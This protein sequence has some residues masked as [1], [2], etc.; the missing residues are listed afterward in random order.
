[1]ISRERSDKPLLKAENIWVVYPDGTIAN[2]G[3]SI[4]VYPGEVHGLLGENGAG[5]TSLVHAIYGVV[6][7]SLGRILVDGREVRI[8][9]PR[10][11][12]RLGIFMVPQHNVLIPRFSGRENI[13]L[14]GD[15]K[16]LARAM[17]IISSI[18]IDLDIESPV[19]TL[20]R[21]LVKK[22]EVIRALATGARLLILD[23]PTSVMSPIEARELLEMIRGLRE[24]GYSFIYI[25]HRLDEVMEV[26]DRVT[27]L[28]GGSVSY[29]GEPS[30]VRVLEERMFREVDVDEGVGEVM[31][32]LN[33]ILGVEGN[34]QLE[35]ARD[36]L[37]YNGF[38]GYVPSYPYA[39]IVPGMS[40]V[41]NVRFRVLDREDV[42]PVET[43]KYILE[44][45]EVLARDIYMDIGKLSGGNIQRFVVGRELEIGRDR[46]VLMFPSR[47][48]DTRSTRLIWMRVREAAERGVDVYYFT[49]DVMEAVN[50]GG[51][52]R[53]M[54]R[55][56]VSDGVDSNEL[57]VEW[58]RRLMSGIGWNA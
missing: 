29:V 55:R 52:V 40:L 39:S 47:G 43:A 45:Y 12:R 41:D 37:T 22:I 38:V 16:T 54:Y 27:I 32:N 56:R 46:C 50:L 42:N 14:A 34:G 18:D 35:Y 5:K 1:V 25:S 23:E 48:L 4:S 3:V 26:C 2:K 7:P 28:R 10:H 51:V 24:M 15:R 58:A 21:G 49:E 9:S 57:D 11:A 13:L 36:L 53:I 30:D 6:R 33:I 44:R 19:E 8:S 20:E 31:D 17:D